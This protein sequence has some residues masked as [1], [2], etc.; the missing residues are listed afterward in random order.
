MCILSCTYF[1]W[2]MYDVDYWK[3]IWW[4][5]SE[6]NDTELYKPKFVIG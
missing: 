1:I 4:M 6:I 2:H 5:E 3:P